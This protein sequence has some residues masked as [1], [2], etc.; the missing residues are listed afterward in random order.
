[1]RGSDSAW[2]AVV[3]A[4]KPSR[5]A[6]HEPGAA[7]TEANYSADLFKLLAKTNL[8]IDGNLWRIGVECQYISEEE[9]AKRNRTAAPQRK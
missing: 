3:A 1:M 7:V 8:K 9:L 4:A 5:N 2:V 6:I